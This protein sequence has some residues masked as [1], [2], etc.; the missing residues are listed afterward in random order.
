MEIAKHH[1]IVTSVPRIR[2]FQWPPRGSLE[3]MRTWTFEKGIAT[4][5][6]YVFM[7]SRW[8]DSP[9]LP[10]KSKLAH[11]MEYTVDYEAGHNMVNLGYIP[12]HRKDTHPPNKCFHCGIPWLDTRQ[13]SPEGESS[14]WFVDIHDGRGWWNGKFGTLFFVD[15]EAWCSGQSFKRHYI[16]KHEDTF[17]R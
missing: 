11:I 3:Y 12:N 1:S 16:E 8:L 7:R 2:D 13:L 5:D 4:F 15:I 10:P 9:A 14:H 6:A 17:S